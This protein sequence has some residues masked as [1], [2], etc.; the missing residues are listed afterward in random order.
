MAHLMTMKRKNPD[1]PR[2]GSNVVRT[3]LRTRLGGDDFPAA[4]FE[5][6]FGIS[7]DQLAKLTLKDL[8]EFAASNLDTNVAK[9]AKKADAVAKILAAA[10]EWLLDD[11]GDNP[12]V[13]PLP[14]G[15]GKD[16]QGDAE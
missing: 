4:A 11:D 7:P 10:R 12:L 2:M 8:R 3:K 13:D 6:K 1:K 14:E 9:N 15:A 5:A 16:G